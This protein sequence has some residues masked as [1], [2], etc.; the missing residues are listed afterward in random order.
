MDFSQWNNDEEQFKSYFNR[1]YKPLLD[2]LA[3]HEELTVK[4]TI[5]LGLLRD[6][7]VTIFGNKE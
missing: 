2:K 4:E 1:T 5:L 6:D 3:A 7:L